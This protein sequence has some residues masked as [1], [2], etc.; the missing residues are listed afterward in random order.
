M[1]DIISSL[2]A[3]VNNRVPPGGFLQA[4]LSNDLQGAFMRADSRNQ[5]RLHG[6]VSYIYNNL[7]MNCYGS[8]IEVEKW[9]EGREGEDE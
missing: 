1:Q 2:E 9:L 3:Y 8:A 6:I 5:I 7:P 4:V